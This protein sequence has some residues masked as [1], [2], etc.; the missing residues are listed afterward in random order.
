MLAGRAGAEIFDEEERPK[1]RVCSAE[2]KENAGEAGFVPQMN[3]MSA[4]TGLRSVFDGAPRKA[5][6]PAAAAKAKGRAG[7]RR[8]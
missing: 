1:K 2:G 3:S 5:S 8:L 4:G 6:A 7:L